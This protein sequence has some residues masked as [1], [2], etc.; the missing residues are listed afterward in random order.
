MC[1]HTA[2]GCI[3]KYC[4]HHTHRCV[5]LYLACL[6][7]RRTRW[8][9]DWPPSCRDCRAA[10]AVCS[11]TTAADRTAS[12]CDAT[13]CD[14]LH[15]KKHTHTARV[16]SQY[17]KHTTVIYNLSKRNSRLKAR[18]ELTTITTLKHLRTWHVHVNVRRS[19]EFYNNNVCQTKSPNKYWYLTLGQCHEVTALT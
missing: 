12:A 5:V 9:A 15:T 7:R 3:H 6:G 17:V 4:A 19:T 2:R 13:F 16:T 18:N 1:A 10:A 8:W 11:H 14:E